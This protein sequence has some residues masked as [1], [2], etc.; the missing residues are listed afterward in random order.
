MLEPLDPP[1]SAQGPIAV[2]GDLDIENCTAQS[3]YEGVFIDPTFGFHV[4]IGGDFTCQGD[5][6][7][8][9]A[10]VGFVTGNVQF[11][12]NP[13]GVTFEAN[14]IGRNVQINNNSGAVVSANAII[15]NLR[16]QGNTSNPTNEG[17]PN[18]VVG[19]EQGQC[20]GL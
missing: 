20:A 2:G 13:G 19:K 8:C 4:A 10:G 15:G 6:N 1:S 3:G 16:C 11:S 18:T 17:F 14:G 12:N 7:G 5:S 9:L